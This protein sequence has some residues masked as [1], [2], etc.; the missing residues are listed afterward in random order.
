MQNCYEDVY[1]KQV[2]TDFGYGK[3]CRHW[4][5]Y[6][7]TNV[8]GEDCV[9]H[10]CTKHGEKTT[11]SLTVLPRLGIVTRSTDERRL[12]QKWPGF[13]YFNTNNTIR[14]V[15]ESQQRKIL[16]MAKERVVELNNGACCEI[17]QQG[18]PLAPCAF[19]PPLIYVSRLCSAARQEEALQETQSRGRI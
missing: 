6:A 9:Y 14:S 19:S 2:Y 13:F 15:S 4:V 16:C 3:P 8:W 17:W 18:S 12:E 5:I 1:T 7:Q 10:R 11:V